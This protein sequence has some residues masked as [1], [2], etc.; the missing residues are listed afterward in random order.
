MTPSFQ[1]DRSPMD[2]QQIRIAGLK[3]RRVKMGS[4]QSPIMSSVHR[5][6]APLWASLSFLISLW[7]GN[8]PLSLPAFSLAVI[9]FVGALQLI[10]VPRMTPDAPNLWDNL[11]QHFPGLLV[12]WIL[13]SLLLL[14][15]DNTLNSSPALTTR[16]MLTWFAMGPFIAAQSSAVS[17]WLARLTGL[18]MIDTHRYVVIGANELALELN[19]RT[20]AAGNQNFMGFFDDRDSTRL[21]GEC[22]QNMLGDLSEV[23]Q[24]VQTHNINAVYITLPVATNARVR[25]VLKELRDTTASVYVVPL[26]M[27]LDTIQARMTEIEGMPLLSVYDTPLDGINALYKRITDIVISGLVLAVIW[28]VLLIIAFGV[29]LSSPGPALFRQHRYGLHGE[30]ITVYKFRSMR[31]QENGKDVVQ[32]VRGDQRITRFGQFLRS[33]SLDELPQIINVLQGRMSLVGP[34]PHA[35]AH[36][37]Q[38]RRL[39]DGYMF[40]HKVRP[41]ITGW[42]Q[43]NG[44][45]GETETI[46][47]MRRRIDYD[48]DYLRQWSLAMDFRI[49]VRTVRLV[50]GDASAY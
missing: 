36:N 37:E 22:G 35:V 13:L 41:G 5:A 42:A 12:D 4:A 3:H 24:Y 39:I 1:P 10:S 49:L 9:V 17:A 44:L 46:D 23:C 47:K 6:L 34:R 14:F 43:V 28:P 7:L 2:T 38:Y 16:Q 21:P 32:A 50:F 48:L 25:K 45:R 29:K 20:Q 19:R 8:A 11:K 26:I 30:R 15:I 31:V 18:T 27:F 33:S 40:R